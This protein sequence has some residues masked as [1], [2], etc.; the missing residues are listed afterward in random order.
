[1]E[2][3]CLDR[4]IPQQSYNDHEKPLHIFGLHILIKLTE[5]LKSIYFSSSRLRGETMTAKR[6]LGISVGEAKCYVK[7]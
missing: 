6:K 1:M 7:H 2:D 3:K 5:N 4:K